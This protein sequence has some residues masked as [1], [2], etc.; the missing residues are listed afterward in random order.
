[1]E[2]YTERLVST[3]GKDTP[4]AACQHTCAVMLENGLDLEQVH[5]DQDPNFFIDRGI[6][7]GI[8]RRFVEDVGK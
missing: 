3:V 5:K 4:K 8:A 6:K 7:I 2:E 1:M